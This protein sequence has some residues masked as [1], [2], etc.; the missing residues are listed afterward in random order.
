MPGLPLE[1]RSFCSWTT[2]PPFAGVTRRRAFFGQFVRLCLCLG[3]Q[4]IFLPVGQPQCNGEVEELNGLWG[5]AFWERRHFSSFAQVC[6]TSPI[7]IQWYLT[8]YVPPFLG[9]ATPQE[10]QQHEPLHHLTARQI[11]QLPDPLPI[12]DGKIHFIR[13]VEADG[14]ISILNESWKVGKRWAG[15][16][17]WANADH[18]LSTI[19]NLVSIF[20]SA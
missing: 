9:D 2:M 20:C 12:T 6:R 16:Y 3:I 14:T 8:D 13:Q 19:G 18:P 5:H 7:F 4:L 15:K 10:A 1:S 11:R 17:V